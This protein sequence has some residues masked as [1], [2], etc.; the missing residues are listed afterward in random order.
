MGELNMKCPKCGA[1]LRHENSNHCDNCGVPLTNSKTSKPKNPNHENLFKGFSQN[2]NNKS[3]STKTKS[4]VSTLN[5]LSTTKPKTSKNKHENLFKGFSQSSKY[6]SN[7]SKNSNKSSSTYNTNN[8]AVSYTS[9]SPS[10]H[11]LEFS[12]SLIGFIITLFGIL[13][14]LINYYGYYD[15]YYFNLSIPL[16]SAII[17]LFGSIIIRYYPKVGAV[18]SVIAGFIVILSGIPLSIIAL[19][20]YIISAILCYARN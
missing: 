15:G 11:P 10:R 13:F 9:T 6:K 20:F 16:L 7:Y 2:T 18:F 4:K 19:F 5:K 8:N 3:K 12:L 17:G 14:V 1:T